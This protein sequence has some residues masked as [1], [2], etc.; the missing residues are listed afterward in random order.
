[1][2]TAKVQIRFAI[3]SYVNCFF[4]WSVIYVDF[5]IFILKLGPLHFRRPAP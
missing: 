1:M 3:K 5:F 2:F 4:V